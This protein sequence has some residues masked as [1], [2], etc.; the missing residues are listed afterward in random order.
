M[1][2]R[3][4]AEFGFAGTETE[5]GEIETD[6]HEEAERAAWDMAVEYVNSWVEE[7]EEEDED[8]FL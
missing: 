1:K 6:S 8:S 3:L 4:K 7:I 2:Y 5:L